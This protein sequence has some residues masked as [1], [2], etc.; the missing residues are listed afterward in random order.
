L[1]PD[2][3]AIALIVN[4]ISKIKSRLLFIGIRGFWQFLPA[5]FASVSELFCGSKKLG[6]DGCPGARA[7]VTATCRLLTSAFINF[8]GRIYPDELARLPM[9][10]G[11]VEDQPQRLACNRNADHFHAIRPTA[12]DIWLLNSV[13]S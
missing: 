9:G 11:C 1:P 10:G 2:P 5:R 8:L 3:L 4:R 6:F 7:V 12:A 13:L